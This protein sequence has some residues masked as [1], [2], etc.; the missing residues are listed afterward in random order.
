MWQEKSLST[1]GLG[2]KVL[3]NLVCRTCWLIIEC[4]SFNWAFQI[5][6]G[7]WNKKEEIKPASRSDKG[8]FHLNYRY[9]ISANS[10]HGNYS[11]LNLTSCTVTF[12][13]STYSC[14]NYSREETIQGRKL[15]AEIW[16]V[17]KLLWGW[18]GWDYNSE[19]VCV[20]GE[21]VMTM[22]W[23]QLMSRYQKKVGEA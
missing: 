17:S 13:Y 7:K 3:R 14:G 18:M 22:Y 21:A 6:S 8:L 4:N 19:S 9:R 15:F 5:G 12:G 23:W 1:K 2:C 11:F 20:C 16:Y 10:F